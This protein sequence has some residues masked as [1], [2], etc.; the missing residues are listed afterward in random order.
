M[1]EYFI[2]ECVKYCVREVYTRIFFYF[3]KIKKCFFYN[4][5]LI[6]DFNHILRMSY[7][8][9]IRIRIFS[10]LLFLFTIPNSPQCFALELLFLVSCLVNLE[11]FPTTGSHQNLHFHYLYYHYVILIFYQ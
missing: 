11:M 8:I 2:Y 10:I 6:H 1:Y 9:F 5:K 7:Y 4:N 3:K